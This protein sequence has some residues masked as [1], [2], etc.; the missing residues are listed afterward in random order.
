MGSKKDAHGAHDEH[1]S[2]EHHTDSHHN[3]TD[4]EGTKVPAGAVEDSITRGSVRLSFFLHAHAHFLP[5]QNDNVTKEGDTSGKQKFADGT[6]GVSG[7][8]E[9][10]TLSGPSQ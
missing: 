10:H 8:N 1:H 3:T 5:S 2:T 9:N 7:T 6:H 4:D